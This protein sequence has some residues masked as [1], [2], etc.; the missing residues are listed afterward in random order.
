M[1]NVT[2]ALAAAALLAT[3]PAAAASDFTVTGGKLDWTIANNYVPGD[4]ARTWLGYA[5]NTQPPG[6]A[7]GNVVATAPAAIT[8]PGGAVVPTV[9]TASAR[10]ADQLYT[11]GYPVASGSYTDK[12]V[13]SI[14]LR[15]TLTFTVHTLPITLVDPLITLDGLTGTLKASGSTASMNGQTSAYDRSKTQFTLD[16]SNATVVLRPN[17]ARTINGIVPVST[18]E[19]VLSGFPPPSRR[20]GTMSL[21]LGLDDV[22]VGTQ[23]GAAG[24]DG[25][26]GATGPA[27][28]DGRDGR[29]ADLRVIR[30]ARAPFATGREVHVR[31]IDRT[32]GKTVAR[33]TVQRR[34]LRLG[35]LTGTTLKGTYLL[36]R[37]AKKASGRLQ[38]TIT[39]R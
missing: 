12:G 4:P 5:T 10:G 11:F 1:R 34:T 27:G 35:V 9:D 15:G 8:G 21:T 20:F 25:A 37:T 13:G 17:G 16:L 14:E 18:A 36:K 24:R 22:P 32:T 28:R 30:L 7:N 29:D 6:A 31:L 23:I 2:F 38:A 3:A 26:A 39:I 33:G 19:S